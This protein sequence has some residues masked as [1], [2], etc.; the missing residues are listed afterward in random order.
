[1]QVLHLDSLPLE[2]SPLHI[3]NELVLLLPLLLISK[4]H[5]VNLLLHLNDVLLPVGWVEM[6]LHLLLQLDLSL[7]EKDLSL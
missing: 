7:P 3:L 1:M 4:L 5:S 6:V 2:H